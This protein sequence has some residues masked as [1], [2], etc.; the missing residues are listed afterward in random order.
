MFIVVFI[1]NTFIRTFTAS[2]RTSST[3]GVARA[4]PLATGIFLLAEMDAQGGMV[5]FTFLTLV[6][7]S[8]APSLILESPRR[9]SRPH[10]ERLR[11][12]AVGS[13]ISL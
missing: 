9:R 11:T 2:R 3:L 8:L 4:K 7:P 12:S 13:D 6:R 5:F 10:S 1:N